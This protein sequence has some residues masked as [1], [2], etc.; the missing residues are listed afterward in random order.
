MEITLRSL[1][2]ASLVCAA[3]SAQAGFTNVAYLDGSY[4]ATQP[5]QNGTVYFVTNSVTF[6]GAYDGRSGL[7]V[8]PGA[9]VVKV[10]SSPT[11]PIPADAPETIATLETLEGGGKALVVPF[12]PTAPSMFY[13]IEVGD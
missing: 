4:D 9:E 5:L 6:D 1:V 8:A 3:G 10:R 13:R 12:N 11:L 2:L 7:A